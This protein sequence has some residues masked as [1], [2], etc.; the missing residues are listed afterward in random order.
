[1]ILNLLC[2][3]LVQYS[4]I[5]SFLDGNMVRRI[6]DDQEFLSEVTD[7][8]LELIKPLWIVHIAL[9]SNLPICPAKLQ[10]YCAV[11]KKKY[12]AQIDWYPLPPAVCSV[13]DHAHQIIQVLPPTI[14]SGMLK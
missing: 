4:H 2:K 5:F 1:M 10:R 7:F 8:P 12:D 3:E 13:L 11:Y 6:F 14:R 9:A